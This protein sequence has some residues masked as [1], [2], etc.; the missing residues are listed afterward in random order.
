VLVIPSTWREPGAGLFGELAEGLRYQLYVVDGMNASGF[1]AE[2]AIREGHQEG[3]LAQARD[4][5]AVARLDFEP[6]LGTVVGLSAY[7]ATSGNSLRGQ[8]GKMPVGMLEADARTRVGGFTARA[9]L[10]ALFIPDAGRLDAELAM[11]AL[12]A[13]DPAPDPVAARAQGAYVEAGYDL[14]RLVLAASPQSL[15]LFGRFD[16]ADTQASVP[17][18]FT[19]NP[20]FRRTTYTAGL[21]YRPVPGVGL[22]LDYRRH[23]YGAGDGRNEIAAAVTWM[24]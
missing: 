5:G 4:F 11:L 14:L 8:V 24:F 3:Q 18:G 21:T 17:A 15:T 19:A 13:G 2:S 23:Q 6:R 12:A 7:Y 1:T 9:E 22:K 20:V 16:Y 10:A